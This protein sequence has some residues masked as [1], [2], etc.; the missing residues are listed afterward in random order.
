MFYLVY[1]NVTYRVYGF[2]YNEKT[3]EA[4]IKE[5]KKTNPQATPAVLPYNMSTYIDTPL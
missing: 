4:R 2:F 1:D 5:L 3:A